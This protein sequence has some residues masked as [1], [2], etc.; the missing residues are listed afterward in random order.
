MTMN[1]VSSLTRDDLRLLV[2]TSRS[3]LL[4]DPRTGSGF[5][6]DSGRGA[7][8]GIT[9]LDGNIWV[10]ARR[11]MAIS[12]FHESEG[13][14]E[15]LVFDRSFRFV[16]SVQPPFPLRELHQILGYNNKLWVT[17]TYDN[18]LAIFDGK[19]WDRWHPKGIPG[20]EVKDQN[21][22]NSLSMIDDHLCVVAHNHGRSELLFFELPE[23]AL[24]HSIPLGVQAHNVWRE[25]DRWMTCSSAEGR[26][27]GSDGFSV[28]TGGFPRGIAFADG[29]SFVGVS[30]H[31]ERALRDFSTSWIQVFDRDWNRLGILD[32]VHEGIVLDLLPVSISAEKMSSSFE[33]V[34]FELRW[35]PGRADAS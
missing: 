25:G 10:A 35:Q 4:L 5:R 23:R 28:L 21:H 6:L 31:C 13:K 18:M 9:M 24:K 22:F 15:V 3:F 29:H 14:G 11:R 20:T 12:P 33:N 8:Y 30:T 16:K 26:I 1:D 32:L 7:Y 34:R 19:D 2:T 27:V 17:C